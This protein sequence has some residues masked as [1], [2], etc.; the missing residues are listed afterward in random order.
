MKALGRFD[1]KDLLQLILLTILKVYSFLIHYTCR[2]T[3]ETDKTSLEMIKEGKAFVA[4]WHGRLIVFPR[5]MHKKGKFAAVVSTHRD[6]EFIAELMHSLGIQ[7][8]RGSSRKGGT[9]AM[10]ELLSLLNQKQRLNIA[11]TPDGPKGPRFNINGNITK[12][13]ARYN[14]PIIPLCF[15]TNRAIVFKT[16]DRFILPLPFSK[17]IIKVGSPIHFSSEKADN[18]D[19]LTGILFK[20]MVSLDKIT[21]LKCDY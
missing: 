6:G 2:F 12:L 13:A 20:Q 19:I 16:W 10:R 3:E 15:S 8:I 1:I 17:I 14:I 18:D 11:I 5:W 21:G 4:L 9:S 7:T